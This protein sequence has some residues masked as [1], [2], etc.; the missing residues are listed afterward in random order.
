MK[1]NRIIS[2][3]TL[4]EMCLLADN[5]LGEGYYSY[6][7]IMETNSVLEKDEEVAILILESHE[8]YDY[9]EARGNIFAFLRHSELK[10]IYTSMYD[11]EKILKS[12]LRSNIDQRIA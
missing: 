12:A 2:F 7:K 4:E 1:E 6:G 3:E 10:V 11:Q 8:Q 9:N 5:E